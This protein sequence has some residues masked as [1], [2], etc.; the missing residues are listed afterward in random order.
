MV[1]TLFEKLPTCQEK[2]KSFLEEMKL[3]S[4]TGDMEMKARADVCDENIDNADVSM[5][6]ISLIMRA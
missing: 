1:E 2:I 6:F 3:A 4:I 5:T